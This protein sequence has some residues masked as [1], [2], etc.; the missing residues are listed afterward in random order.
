MTK[1]G[2]DRI[3]LGC[4]TLAL[5]IAIINAITHGMFRWLTSIYWAAV[6]IYWIVTL[7]R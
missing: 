7:R 3:K 1:E 4:A 5:L 6:T 2:K